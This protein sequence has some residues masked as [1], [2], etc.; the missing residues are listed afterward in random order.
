VK[1]V[2]RNGTEF[3]YLREKLGCNMS[4][5]IHFMSSHLDYCLENC[6]SVS[7]EHNERFHQNFAAMEGRYKWKLSPS[8]IADYCW[9]LKH[10]SPNSTFNRQAKQVRLQLRYTQ[11]LTYDVIQVRDDASKTIANEAF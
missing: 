11:P 10:D 5:K 7:D 9:T 4:L 1:A 3:L 2:D 8:M 6:G